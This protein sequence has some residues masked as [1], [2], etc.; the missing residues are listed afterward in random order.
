MLF[1]FVGGDANA[2]DAINCDVRSVIVHLKNGE[3]MEIAPVLFVFCA[4]RK[5][6]LN[7]P[8]ITKEEYRL[9]FTLANG[10]KMLY[11]YALEF[12]LVSVIDKDAEQ[13]LQAMLIEEQNEL[14]Y[15]HNIVFTSLFEQYMKGEEALK[16]LMLK[17]QEYVDL[18]C[19]DIVTQVQN[20]NSPSQ[21][22]LSRGKQFGELYESFFNIV[23][24]NAASICKVFNA[25]S[26]NENDLC[27]L[28][29]RGLFLSMCIR[30][31]KETVS[32]IKNIESYF[33]SSS[34]NFCFTT[35]SSNELRDLVLCGYYLLTDYDFM[36][37]K[38]R[39]FSSTG[40]NFPPFSEHNLL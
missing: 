9:F 32:D 4:A 15:G 19:K 21:D 40:S 33:N 14:S 17:C 30:L 31:K 39:I 16:E 37:L 3:K 10:M 36:N 12:F 27:Y 22:N 24:E 6:S 38:M 28:R 13:I 25:L 11:K 20:R 5:H 34:E 18:L 2:G 8:T 26:Y 7:L 35:L 29:M 1:V 23:Q